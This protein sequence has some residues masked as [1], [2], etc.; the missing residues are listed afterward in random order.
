[1]NFKLNEVIVDFG[2]TF[3]KNFFLVDV[4]A[5]AVYND[6]VKT[7]D[8][9]YSYLICVGDRKMRQINV[10]IPG[11]QLLPTPENGSFTK[12]ELIDP[13]VKQYYMNNQYGLSISAT[14]IKEVK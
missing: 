13:V 3:G 9:T 5:K 2:A 1:M 11:N 6:G 4:I 14:S 8:V 10:K 7:D 12:V